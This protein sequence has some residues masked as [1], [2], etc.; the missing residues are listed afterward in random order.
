MSVSSFSLT[1]EAVRFEA[2]SGAGW[3]ASEQGGVQIYHLA[4]YSSD[5]PNKCLIT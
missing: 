5:H 2:A 1:Q 3:D 4:L